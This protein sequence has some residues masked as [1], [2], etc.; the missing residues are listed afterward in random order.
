MAMI[1]W[2]DKAKELGQLDFLGMWHR[3]Q[4]VLVERTVTH[5]IVYKLDDTIHIDS[6][7]ISKDAALFFLRLWARSEWETEGIEDAEFETMSLSRLKD[8]F[9]TSYDE[10][11]AWVDIVVVDTPT[12]VLEDPNEL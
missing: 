1:K 6:F 3:L 5:A 8:L 4:Q 9:A 11:G 10:R 12:K 7:H 2:R